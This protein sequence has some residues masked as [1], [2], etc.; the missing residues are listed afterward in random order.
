MQNTHTFFGVEISEELSKAESLPYE[1]I[2]ET[3]VEGNVGLPVLAF[4]SN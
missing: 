1:P 2:P 4:S 3:H